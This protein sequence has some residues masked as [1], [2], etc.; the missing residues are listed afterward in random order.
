[1]TIACKRAA[2]DTDVCSYCTQVLPDD[3][4]CPFV[5]LGVP[6]GG[7]DGAGVT[8]D[9]VCDPSAGICEGCT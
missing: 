7:T 4:N 6:E 3:L 2:T 1:M 8:P 5:G 9:K